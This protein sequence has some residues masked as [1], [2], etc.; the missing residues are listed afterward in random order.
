MQFSVDVAGQSYYVRRMEGRMFLNGQAHPILIDYE[1]G[2]IRISSLVPHDHQ[3]ELI[4]RAVCRA[5][6]HALEPIGSVRPRGLVPLLDYP[7]D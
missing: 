1:A 6:H 4:A 5:W 7:L 2:E 3:A